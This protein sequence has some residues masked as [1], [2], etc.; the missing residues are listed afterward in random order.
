RRSDTHA[1]GDRS[2]I[3]KDGNTLT[4]DHIYP[5]HVMVKSVETPHYLYTLQR[6]K[7]LEKEG[8]LTVS[9]KTSGNPLVM[10]N[11]LTT[12]PSGQEPSI[13]TSIGEGHIFG[14]IDGAMFAVNTRPGHIYEGEGVVTDALVGT[15]DESQIFA[16][17]FTT[18][19][20]NGSL[21]MESEEPITAEIEG[22][23]IRYYCSSDTK[24]GIGSSLKPTHVTVNGADAAS[25]GYDEKRSAV[26]L[27]LPAGEGTVNID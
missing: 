8:M 19:S 9:S 12:S 6:E 21:V 13:D 14:S 5:E 16:A 1:T 20:L 23:R 7:P 24:V 26:E 11:L 22:G 3:T 25:F 17:L 10:A 18:L 2:T 27:T 4:I 15:G